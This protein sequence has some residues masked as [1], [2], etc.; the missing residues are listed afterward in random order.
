MKYTMKYI[1]KYRLKYTRKKEMEYSVSV[2]F[3]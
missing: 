1:M 2:Y 3:L